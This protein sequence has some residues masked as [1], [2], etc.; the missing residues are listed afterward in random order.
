M[1]LRRLLATLLVLPVTAGADLSAFRTGPVFDRH[2]PVAD[3][4]TTYSIPDD[5]VFRHSFDVS[6]QAEDG[7]ANRTLD[8]AA[9]FIN[10]HARAG[11]SLERIELAI[12]VHGKAVHDVSGDAPGN[13]ELV[14]TLI[15]AGVKIIVCGQSAAYYDVATDE[16]LPG[17]AMALSAM[18]AHAVLQQQGYTLNPF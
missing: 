7:A 3:V 10:M 17:V 12:V 8:S 2:G 9:R 15:D 11:I 18:S 16:L 14:A 1:R 5:I 13:A 6:K 4:E